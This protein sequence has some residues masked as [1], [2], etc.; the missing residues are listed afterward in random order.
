M[1]NTPGMVTV[2]ES[3]L[4]ERLLALQSFL[5]MEGIPTQARNLGL[6][7]DTH[8]GASV[9]ATPL[10]EVAEADAE[11]ARA[12]IAEHDQAPDGDEV[13]DERPPRI[14]R[15]CGEESPA[16]FDLCWSCDAPLAEGEA[17]E[18]S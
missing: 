15:Y 14:C 11:R 4:V 12:L 18:L 6:L 8:F 5:E 3:M 1:V 9:W 17:G 2:Y 16:G 13:E 7:L 10:L